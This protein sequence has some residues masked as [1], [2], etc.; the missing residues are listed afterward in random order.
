MYIGD[1]DRPIVMEERKNLDRTDFADKDFQVSMGIEAL[2]NNR[3]KISDTSEVDEGDVISQ[4][5]YLNV[6]EYNRFLQ[7]LDLDK[8][9]N[10]TDFYNLY[11]CAE[12]DNL[13]AKLIVLN[14]KLNEL[15]TSGN[16]TIHSFDNTN[17]IEMQ[18]NYNNLINELNIIDTVTEFKDYI[19]SEGTLEFEYVVT[20]VYRLTNEI[21]IFES[22]EFVQGNLTIYKR[23]VSVGQMN[24]IT[25]GDPSA[26]KQ[27]NKGYLLFDQ[28]NFFKMLLEYATD[29]SQSFDGHT[30]RGKGAG[31]WGSSTWG[32]EDRNYWGGDGN[33]APRRVIIPKNKQRCRYITVRFTHSTARDMYKITGAAHDVRSFSA[34]AYK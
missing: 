17:W 28:N 9:L 26:F 32:F 33:D 34:L 21:S 24:P 23:I 20:A 22:T 19:Q 25:F 27:V 5:Q 29:L 4:I 8:G 13:A 16:I 2:V 31:F 18:I 11:N 3:Y 14:I 6:S 1:G 7:K 10:Y 30:F 15:D 12:A